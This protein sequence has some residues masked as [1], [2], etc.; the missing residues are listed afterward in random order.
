MAHFKDH[1][2][3]KKILQEVV[4]AENLD[5]AVLEPR[6]ESLRSRRRRAAYEEVV[7]ELNSSDDDLDD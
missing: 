1:F 7:D 3:L 5:D 2:V 4:G 6:R